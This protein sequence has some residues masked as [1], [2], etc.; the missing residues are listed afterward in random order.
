MVVESR[1]PRGD[2]EGI[3]EGDIITDPPP[4]ISHHSLFS[5]PHGQSQSVGKVFIETSSE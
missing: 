2:F 4:P 3:E 5:A 1:L